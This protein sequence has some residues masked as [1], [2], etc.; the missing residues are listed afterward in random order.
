MAITTIMKA[1]RLLPAS[2]ALKLLQKYNPKF[3]NHFANAAAYGYDVNNALD[4]LNERFEGDQPFRQQL[5]QGEANGQ[6]RPD[7]RISKNALENAE[8]PRKIARSAA[9]IGGGA[10]LGGVPGA[11]AGVAAEAIPQAQQPQQQPQREPGAR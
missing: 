11:T 3:K 2:A 10:L 5:E 7:E 4:Y 6:L 8:T 1:A 9:A